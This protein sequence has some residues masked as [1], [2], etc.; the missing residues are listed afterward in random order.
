M[1]VNDLTCQG[2]FSGLMHFTLYRQ[3]HFFY[4][5]NIT[6]NYYFRNI[7]LYLFS[8]S[9]INFK[10]ALKYKKLNFLSQLVDY[11]VDIRICKY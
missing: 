11:N 2:L 4:L 7:I 3:T 8:K 1:N 6:E 5:Q 10:T 9:K